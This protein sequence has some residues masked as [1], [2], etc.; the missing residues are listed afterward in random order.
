MCV[1]GA[2]RPLLQVSRRVA[3][4][5]AGGVAGEK[6]H[7]SRES[8]P[9]NNI[10]QGLLILFVRTTFNYHTEGLFCRKTQSQ[11]W[12]EFNQIIKIKVYLKTS[13]KNRKLSND[14]YIIN[15][16]FKWF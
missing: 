15:Y 16:Y 13:F 9:N 10:F 7:G 6:C 14:I 2:R 1:K 12:I 5:G 8:V 11:N 3:V 4:C